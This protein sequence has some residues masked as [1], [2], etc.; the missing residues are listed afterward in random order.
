MQPRMTNERAS[1]LSTSA[2]PS[3]PLIAIQALERLYTKL[4]QRPNP[5]RSAL[6]LR[7][8]QCEHGCDV[9]Y[10]TCAVIPERIAWWEAEL[11]KSCGTA[12]VGRC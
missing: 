7:S 12:A 9:C 8:P 2:H 5:E 3:A 10:L 4:A 1:A 6:V 11:A